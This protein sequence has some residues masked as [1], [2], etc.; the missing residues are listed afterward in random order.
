M[1]GGGRACVCVK[2]AAATW[3]PE[4]S[5]PLSHPCC[6]YA[7]REFQQ[8]IQLLLE[9]V[10][11]APGLPH[12]YHTLGLIYEETGQVGK[13]LKLFMMAA[14]LSKRDVQQWKQLA[15]LSKQHG[16]TQQCIYCL[17]RVLALKPDDQ[18]AQWEYGLLLSETGEHRKAA[19]TL[20]PLLRNRPD[21]GHVLHRLVRSYHRLGHAAKATH[22]LEAL[23]APTFSGAAGGSAG[24]GSAGGGGAGGGSS[25]AP[26]QGADAGAAAATCSAGAGGTSKASAGVTGSL[27]P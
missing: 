13:A 23:L 17:Q 22:L 16:E 27:S 8:A 21:D 12:A 19:K 20:L 3:R 1:G 7:Y 26:T 14:H 18:D 24:G 4:A 11:I 9:V 2:S 15:F 25:S 5:S 10:R 6:R